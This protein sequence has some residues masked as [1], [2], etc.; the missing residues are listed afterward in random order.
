LK[1]PRGKK[2]SGKKG[3]RREREGRKL[4]LD[5]GTTSSLNSKEGMMARA[6][7]FFLPV[8]RDRAKRG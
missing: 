3:F 6:R 7:G 1:K 2:A 5:A 4:N 8:S